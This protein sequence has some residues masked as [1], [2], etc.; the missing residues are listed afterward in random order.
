[1]IDPPDC[2][3]FLWSFPITA[4]G[5][6]LSSFVLTPDPL[7]FLLCS[8]LP[9]VSF[10]FVFGLQ[11]FLTSCFWITCR[12]YRSSSRSSSSWSLLCLHSTTLSAMYV[13]S[14]PISVFFKHCSSD[15]TACLFASSS[16]NRFF[17]GRLCHWIPALPRL[18]FN[19][20]RSVRHFRQF[21]YR[22]I[23]DSLASPR[24]Q[25]LAVS[26]TPILLRN[27]SIAPC[28]TFN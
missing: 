26:T 8:I 18:I 22:C 21:V 1:M 12:G 14:A 25:H 19:V 5:V 7:F 17:S 23:T 16:A 28:S 4:L 6:T 10:C 13:F 24:H 3:P 11:A 27:V 20:R 9:S 2:Q 15:P